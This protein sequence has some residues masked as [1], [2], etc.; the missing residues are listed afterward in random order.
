LRGGFDFGWRGLLDADG[1]SLD[2]LVRQFDF[3]FFSRI[4]EQEGGIA[5]TRRDRRFEYVG[6]CNRTCA[7]QVVLLGGKENFLLLS[8]WSRQRDRDF[9]RAWREGLVLLEQPDTESRLAP[10][11]DSSNSKPKPSSVK[12]LPPCGPD[13][14]ASS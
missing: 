12:S 5:Q 6:F 7:L 1:G 2:L 14:G 3:S 8:P 4:D 13:F 11:S 9:G 10:S